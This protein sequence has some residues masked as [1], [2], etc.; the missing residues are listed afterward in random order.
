[1]T[2][3]ISAGAFIFMVGLFVQL[4]GLLTRVGHTVTPTPSLV[5]Q[6]F[7]VFISFIGICVLMVFRG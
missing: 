1:M 3:S 4:G 6:G 5:M 7:G 2:V